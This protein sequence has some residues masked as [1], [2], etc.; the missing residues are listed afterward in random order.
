[1]KQ[2]IWL[3]LCWLLLAVAM[4]VVCSGCGLLGTVLYQSNTDAESVILSED[5][6]PQNSSTSTDDTQTTTQSTEEAQPPADTPIF[7][8]DKYEAEV[9]ADYAADADLPE[10]QS[11]AGMCEL[12]DKYAQRWQKIADQYYDKLL[13]YELEEDIST[14]YCSVEEYR[15]ALA[16]MKAAHEDFVEKEMT[17]YSTV[18]RYE[19]QGGTIC[20]PIAADHRYELEKAWALKILDLCDSMGIT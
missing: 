10:Y 16:D 7:L 17:A 15:T 20:G 11:T 18:L 14:P 19:Y 13:A 5:P 9:E 3:R 8:R 2:R 6:I 4:T 12:G 1:M